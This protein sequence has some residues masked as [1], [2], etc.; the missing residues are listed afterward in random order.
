MKW[1]LADSALFLGSSG[2]QIGSFSKDDGDGNENLRKATGLDL[3]NNNASFHVYHFFLYSSLP[4][5]LDLDVKMPNFIFYGGRK[6]AMTN[7]SF[8]F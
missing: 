3:Q 6:Q 2:F 4:S 1:R 5:L 8:S 7:F